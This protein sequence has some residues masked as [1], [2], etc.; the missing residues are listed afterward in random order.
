MQT[1][2]IQFA[3]EILFGQRRP[4]IRQVGLVTDQ[5]DL[6]A[7]FLQLQRSYYL[8]GSM[9]STCDYNSIS[10]DKNARFEA[11]DRLQRPKNRQQHHH[12]Y[13]DD[14]CKWHANF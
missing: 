13:E 4:L 1:F 14:D 12:G 5:Y 2:R 11:L 3:G 9:A 7:E 8:S 6:A 10:Q